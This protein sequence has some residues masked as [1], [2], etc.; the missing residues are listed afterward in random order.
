MSIEKT[1]PQTQEQR[2]PNTQEC[3]RE[4]AR[5][6]TP[7]VDIIE[8]KDKLVLQADVPGVAKDA[9]K[10]NVENNVLTL[11]ANHAVDAEHEATYREYELANFYR[12]FEFSEQIDADKISA[13]L[14][15]GVLTLHL[16]K[17]EK[18]KPKQIPVAY[19]E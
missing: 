12:Q 19:A 11:E 15:N 14:K 3:S 17:V 16:P 5:Y 4:D 18:V 13:E 6:V 7:P 1:V 2:V 9:V 8:Y 10:V